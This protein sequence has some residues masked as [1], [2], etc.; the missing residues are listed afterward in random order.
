[1]STMSALLR[2]DAIRT[3]PV[4]VH[5][6]GI[7]HEKHPIAGRLRGCFGDLVRHDTGPK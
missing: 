3:P 4:P 5:A 1:M 6:F 7:N 2:L